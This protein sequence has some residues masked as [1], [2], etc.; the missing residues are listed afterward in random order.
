MALCEKPW[1]LKRRF[2]NVESLPETAKERK[3][4]QGGGAGAG[5]VASEQADDFAGRVEVDLP[6]AGACPQSGHRLHVAEDGVEEA[7]TG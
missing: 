5:M 7:G 4:E 2:G 3:R 1:S 6:E